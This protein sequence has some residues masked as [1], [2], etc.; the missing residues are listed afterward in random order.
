MAIQGGDVLHPYQFDDVLYQLPAVTDYQISLGKE[1][2]KHRI[3]FTVEVVGEDMR[4]QK[5]IGERLMEHDFIKGNLQRN[6]IREPEITVVG[7][8]ALKKDRNL[9]RSTIQMG[10]FNS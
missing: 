9:K 1:N 8:G 7:P 5:K 3:M 2:G 4:L 10:A 6:N